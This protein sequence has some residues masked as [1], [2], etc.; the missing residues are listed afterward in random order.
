MRQRRPPRLDEILDIHAGLLRHVNRPGTLA[1][2]KLHSGDLVKAAVDA[3]QAEIRHRPL[4]AG[5]VYA[6]DGH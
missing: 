2:G 5:V 4:P 6:G 3:L 1:A